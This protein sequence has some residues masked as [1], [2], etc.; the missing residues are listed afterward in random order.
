MPLIQNPVLTGFNADPSI[1]RNGSDFYI[2]TSTFDWYPGVQISHSRDLVHWHVVARP[3]DRL[4]QLDLRGNQN[5]G[6]VWAPCLSWADG[7]FWLIYTNVRRWTGAFK[8]SH[9]Y[10]VTAESIEGPW[11]EPVYLNSS[12]FDPSLFHDEGRKWLVNMLWDARPSHTPFGG[13]LLQE[14]DAAAGRL[15]G[16]V[17]RIFGGSSLGLVEGPH[18]LKRAGWYY[19][20]TAEG[21]TFATHAVTVARSRS[22]EGPY[23]TMPGN[24]LLTS[25]DDPSLDLQSAGHGQFIELADGSWYL[26][27]LCRRPRAK[28]RTVLGRETALQKL[29]W[30]EDGWPRLACGGHSPETTTPAP[31]LPAAVWH[32]FPERDDFD[33]PKLNLAWQSWRTPLAANVHS[34]AARPGHLRLY[35]RESIQSVF[36]QSLVA[37]RQTAFHI[38]ASTVLEVS[39]GDF[40]HAAGLVAFYSTDNF[41]Y[42]FVTRT[43]H[44]DRALGLMACE[45]GH[46]SYPVEKEYPLKAEGPVHLRLEIDGARLRF[47][48]GDDGVTWYPV[49]WELDASI[50]SDE[51]AIP[52]GFTGNFVGLACQDLSGQGRW[53]DFDRFDYR[54][55]R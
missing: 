2:A 4:S 14:F 27:H 25:A 55:V 34:L 36:D 32:P 20:V 28:G 50:L 24:P 41:Y 46:V 16:P 33:A 49:G 30:D 21:G 22:V 18:L 12:G 54:E 39:P 35:G 8:D 15:K 23:E 9:N 1:C 7:K 40:Q 5:S 3:L 6:G 13:I 26:A 11:S 52:C 10:L 29:T 45:K 19:L 47:W 38:E 53:A 44:A 17:T 48:Y 51:H 42:L 43:E 31:N 37:R